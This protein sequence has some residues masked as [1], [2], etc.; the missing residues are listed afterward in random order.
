MGRAGYY[1]DCDNDWSL[2]MWRGAVASSIKGKRGQA[3]LK[4]LLEALDAMPVKELVYHDLKNDQGVCALGC[5]GTKR[6][7]DLETLDPED[8]NGLS[9][10]FNIAEPLVREI[11]YIN[12][13]A[14]TRT[15][16]PNARWERVRAW[17]ASQIKQSKLG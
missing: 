12:D 16:S 11:E 3:F 4:D 15:E 5:I 13:E 7:I 6:E 17:V 1:D 8:W 10:T 9:K 14:N 2:I